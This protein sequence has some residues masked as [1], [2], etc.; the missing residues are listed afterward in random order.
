MSVIKGSIAQSTNIANSSDNPFVSSNLHQI[1]N[2]RPA[3]P[4]SQYELSSSKIGVNNKFFINDLSLKRKG[5]DD[6]FNTVNPYSN[7][8]LFTYN[9][10]YDGNRLNAGNKS[11]DTVLK[12]AVNNL[13]FE[14]K[15]ID[16]ILVT[17]NQGVS[18]D[19]ISAG[20]T[21]NSKSFTIFDL[22]ISVE[23]PSSFEAEIIFR[24][25]NDSFDYKYVVSGSRSVLF[26]FRPEKN[27]Q[28]ITGFYTNVK[29]SVTG[30]ETRINL[31]KT[32]RRSVEYTAKLFDTQERNLFDNILT[33]YQSNLFSV[34][35]W[36]ELEQLT[37]A[38]S[39]GTNELFVNTATSNFFA[40]TECFIQRQDKTFEVITI[41]SVELNKLILKENIV[42][43]YPPNSLV[44]PVLN[45]YMRNKASLNQYAGEQGVAGV[46]FD[47]ISNK[48]IDTFTPT[49]TYNNVPVF[50]Y[51]C[52]IS[53]TRNFDINSFSETID[54]EIGVFSL[55]NLRDFYTRTYQHGVVL[56]NKEEIWKF[57]E[58]INWTRGR[59]NSFYT[60]TIDSSMELYDNV[61]TGGTAFNV[62]KTDLSQ[63]LD[64]SL[65]RKSIKIQ[66]G[67]D[68]QFVDV[69]NYNY[70]EGQE[71]EIVNIT[72]PLTHDIVV[73]Q[74]KISW[75]VRVR[76]ANDKINMNYVRA[77]LLECSLPLV[78]V[79]E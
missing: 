12:I 45:G 26:P 68:I 8:V 48:F 50:E 75:L 41:E 33:K 14:H 55:F 34:P 18:I 66:T 58:F 53:G 27:I 46:T 4:F 69:V 38:V 22:T 23:G 32:S 1:D 49:T 35:V 17:E 36:H 54:Y 20:Q 28:D 52:I 62:K 37:S 76:L 6:K 15:V 3:T 21:L 70:I 61:L 72:E 25:V 10:I 42:N 16:N 29:T 64:G 43:D 47:L 59:L 78:E 79:D 13:F 44:V 71:F 57:R 19:N 56:K 65:T 63:T 7:N 77:N 11:T 9:E 51:P 40:D 73:G 30:A 24:F 31:R 67:S 74:T 60:S 2:R 39:S 5:S